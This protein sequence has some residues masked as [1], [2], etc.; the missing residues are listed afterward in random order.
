MESLCLRRLP[1]CSLPGALQMA[2]DAWLLESVTQ[3]ERL[4][5]LRDDSR[6]C[7]VPAGVQPFSMGVISPMP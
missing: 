5:P 3:G 2:T 4:G 7:V 1:S 6:W